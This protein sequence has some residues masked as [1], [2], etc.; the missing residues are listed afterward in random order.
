MHPTLQPFLLENT[1][2]EIPQ[3]ET[4][5]GKIFQQTDK[6]NETNLQDQT[7][8]TQE[9]CG[10]PKRKLLHGYPWCRASQLFQSACAKIIEAVNVMQNEK[11]VSR[12]GMNRDKCDSMSGKLINILKKNIRDTREQGAMGKS[13]V[14]YL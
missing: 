13:Q 4:S 14:W 3:T 10:N 8:F 6:M 9:L 1:S 5:A 11:A 7:A 12:E 2:A